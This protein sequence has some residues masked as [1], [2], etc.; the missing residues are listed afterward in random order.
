[1]PPP[2]S[3]TPEH[4]PE[5]ASPG[6]TI[7]DY[8]LIIKD[9]WFLG[10]FFGLLAAAP[11]FWTKWNEVPKYESLTILFFEQAE[12]SPLQWSDA[13]RSLKGNT[14]DVMQG[15]MYQLNSREMLSRVVDTLSEEERETVL[16]P[17]RTEENPDI[18]LVEVVAGARGFHFGNGPFII[19]VKTVHRD[20]AAAA[21]LAN[22]FSEQYIDY[23]IEK[24][25]Q[26]NAS[27][28]RFLEKEV[29]ELRRAV[30]AGEL[31]LQEYREEHALV[32]LR[33]DQNIVVQKLNRLSEALGAARLDQTRIDTQIEQVDRAG[34]ET[35]R[36]VEVPV[37]NQFPELRSV[38]T[39]INTLRTQKATLAVKYLERH[40]RMID[41]NARLEALEQ[42][43]EQLLRQ[44]LAEL[45]GQKRQADA[46][47]SRL[48]G[49]LTE[50]E[51]TALDLERQSVEY[52]AL[53]R[54]LESDRRTFAQLQSRLNETQI[55]TKLPTTNIRLLERAGLS[56]EPIS[57][58]KKRIIMMSSMLFLALFA[59]VPI[60]L[61]MMG[62]KIKTRA[63]I[64]NFLQ[65]ELL[66]AIP[67]V[68]VLERE[69]LPR[70]VLDESEDLV[71]EHFNNLYSQIE[72]FSQA[73]PPKVMLVTGA[74]TEE[75]KSFVASNLAAIFAKHKHRTLLFD[76]DLRHPRQHSY[77]KLSNEHG[78]L[79]WF[80]SKHPGATFDGKAHEIAELGIQS[81]AENLHLLPAGGSTNRPT[82]VIG[83]DR[84]ANLVAALK[85][86][87]DIIIIDSPPAIFFPD[88]VMLAEYAEEI[89]HVCRHN[90]VGRLKV[91]ALLQKL[92][93][94]SARV[95]GVVFNRAKQSDAGR[96]G[97]YDY[98]AYHKYAAERARPEGGKKK[99]ASGGD[100]KVAATG[101]D[102]PPANS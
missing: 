25:Q 30:S 65:R 58:N 51:K 83:S 63:D 59:G 84:F 89:V 54:K 90:L 81:L 24:N 61:E 101:A 73:S 15:H 8:L 71:Y 62:N 7:K 43:K 41:L 17:Y 79:R 14:E 20:P 67:R 98:K 42:S 102:S 74:T 100:E 69:K 10:L 55:A 45:Q 39:E 93:H 97:Y 86:S 88:A 82:P 34:G 3:L 2:A 78:V 4:G 27:A 29:E 94:S 76:A 77:H 64:E 44:A 22:R 32:S 85:Q 91:R 96:L 57:P 28:T 40:P 48:R 47:V 68:R 56:H 38:L 31:A 33:D 12:N 53:Q 36:L 49:E 66:A 72:L 5:N 26:T 50:A 19:R 75:G 21:L 6:R 92:D 37:V 16:A 52:N 9:R 46:L 99:K 1:M 70:I 18:S 60:G 13:D 23:E 87:Y 35:A 95:L 11:F 80:H